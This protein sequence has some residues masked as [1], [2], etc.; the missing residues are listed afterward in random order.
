MT[1]RGADR[2]A[3]SGPRWVFGADPVWKASTS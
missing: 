3:R 1:A 2:Q